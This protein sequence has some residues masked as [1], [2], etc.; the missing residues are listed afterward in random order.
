MGLMPPRRQ[1]ITPAPWELRSQTATGSCN[2]DTVG[3]LHNRLLYFSQRNHK[4]TIKVQMRL[5]Q[6]V[7]RQG[8]HCASDTPMKRAD[9]NNS[10]SEVGYC[11]CSR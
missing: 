2:P 5:H 4:L 1:A 7:C 9:L 10:R 11:R 8:I 6:L 3:Q